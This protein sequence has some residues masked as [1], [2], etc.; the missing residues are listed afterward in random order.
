MPRRWLAN[1]GGPQ[2]AS[3]TAV[4]ILLKVMADAGT[5]PSTRV[6]V[7]DSV[8]NH[9]AKAIESDDI[10]AR[11]TD[12]LSPSTLTKAPTACKPSMT[13]YPSI[14]APT[15]FTV[16]SAI[17][18]AGNTSDPIQTGAI[19]SWSSDGAT[20]RSVKAGSNVAA[21]TARYMT[22][23]AGGDRHCRS[24][25]LLPIGSRQREVAE[26]LCCRAWIL[27][28]RGCRPSET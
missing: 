9:T 25:I 19:M 15:T 27:T 1:R 5:P 6:R 10:E 7:V 21:D 4:S 18:A 2:Q 28:E 23:S 26:E 12:S 3:A 16:V 24:G 14:N 8:L 20:A 17:T 11:L 22:F 13:V